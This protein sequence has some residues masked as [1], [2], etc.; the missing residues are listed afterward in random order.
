MNVFVRSITCARRSLT[1]VD[2]ALFVVSRVA[3][4]RNRFGDH[5]L[6]RFIVRLEVDRVVRHRLTRA[7]EQQER[8][9]RISR[10]SD[11]RM[12]LS[13]EMLHR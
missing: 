2:L 13:I 12:K 4:H 6:L 1:H 7:L 5:F 9:E 11:S 10:P 3:H 8:L